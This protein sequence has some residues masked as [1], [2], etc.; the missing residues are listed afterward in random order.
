[1]KRIFSALL[2]ICILLCG[3]V[4]AEEAAV[5]L[6]TNRDILSGIGRNIE[7]YGVYGQFDSE[8]L[9]LSTLSGILDKHPEMYDEVLKIMLSSMDKYGAYYTPEEA[10]KFL[11]NLS[12]SITGIG[13]TV[14]SIDGNLI[15]NQVMPETPAERAGLAA[16]DIIISA[17][18]V[19]LTGMDLD[20]AISHIRG[21]VG[22]SVSLTVI[23]GNLGQLTFSIVRDNII[24]SPI[25]YEILD[26][27]IGYIRIYSFA[28]H[29][30]DYVSE[31]L[32]AFSE[33]GIKDIIIDLRDNGGGYLSEAVAIADMFLPE[34]KII[35]KE[36]HRLDLFDRTY[37]ATG[38]DPGYNTA[39][40]I[41]ENSA[42]AS[43]VLTAALAEN[44]Y[45]TTIGE[46]SYGKGTVQTM[47]GL[48]SGGIIKYTVAFYLTPLGKNIDEIG[49]SPDLNVNNTL[50]PVDLT[51]FTEPSYKN[52]Y[53]VGMSSPEIRYIKE[54]LAYMGV[55]SGEVNDY[56]DENLRIV[57]EALQKSI[58]P[59]TPSG[60]L[61][62]A[63]Q[64]NIFGFLGQSKVRADNQLTVAK[65]FLLEK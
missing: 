16:G 34:G 23:R 64:I 65:N 11:E 48:I 61:D 24:S 28:E 55:Y 35:T 33:K 51:Q 58:S 8:E 25:D 40:L 57:L 22:T 5:P 43:E 32:A 17:D 42:S 36:D 47:N 29:T 53:Y 50:E 49:I 13:I 7:L 41:N 4:F 18:G 38:A 21:T 45:A 9:Y 14:N 26:D 15:I 60:T 31:A 6:Y 2:I 10:E 20:A 52:T 3:C 44:N 39:I 59:S 63:M 37:T 12:D 62:P 46:R 19:N 54:M 1:M 27:G 30:S 56:F